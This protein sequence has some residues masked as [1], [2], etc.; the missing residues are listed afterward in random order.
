MTTPAT[1]ADRPRFPWRSAAAGWGAFALLAAVGVPLFLRMPLWIDVTLYDMAARAVLSGGVHYRDVFDTNPPGFVWL[2]CAIRSVLGPSIEAVRVVDLAIVCVVGYFLLRAAREAGATAAGVAWAAAGFAGFYLFIS[3][4]NHAQRDVWMMAPALAAVG[5]RVKRVR[6]ARSRPVSDGWVLR[7]SAAEGLM[8]GAAVWVKPHVFFVAVAVWLAVQG[9]LAGSVPAGRRLRRTGADLL[10][11]LCGGLVMGT[12]GLTWLVKSGTWPHFLDVFTQWNTSYIR[13]VF[14]EFDDRIEC[15]L[16]YF[17]PWSLFVVLAVP[18]AVANVIDARPWV[19]RK[20]DEG[21]G[22]VTQSLPW[23]LYSPPTD[24]EARATRGVLAAVY[25]SWLLTALLLQKQF[26]YV[27]VPE[28]L[29]MI[30]LFAANRWAVTVAVLALQAV[31]MGW[32]ALIPVLGTPPAPSWGWEGV[33]FRHV[34]WEY[35]NRDPDRL[36]WWP[37]CFSRHVPGEVRNGVAFQSDYFAGIDT[38]E[39]DEVAEYLRSQNVREGE[40][41]AYND[42]PHAVY[43]V[44]GHRRPPIRFMHLSTATLMGDEQYEWVKKEVTAAAPGVRFV[45]SDL[46]RLATFYSYEDLQRVSEPGPNAEDHLPPV[47]PMASRDVFPLNQPTVFRS[48]GGRGR[49][50]VHVLTAPVGE[51]YYPGY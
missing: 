27:H 29:L 17:P 23:W 49:Y 9:G 43:L 28:T 40:V 24:A 18:V 36:K 16:A 41:M 15:Q 26:H 32:L 42:S 50:V 33:V 6:T 38:A 8:W 10:G 45:V 46:Q 3:E 51:I 48:G 44:L 21:A 19:I 13:Q 20:A 7:T 4:F 14:D 2:M 34:I 37:C 31:V 11:A 25:L 12:L 35:P 5:Y 39:I 47:V 1:P 22:S 30:A